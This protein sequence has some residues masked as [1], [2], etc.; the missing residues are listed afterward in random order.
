MFLESSGVQVTKVNITDLQLL[1]VPRKFQALQE[2]LKG[3]R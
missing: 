3:T 1:H 2:E